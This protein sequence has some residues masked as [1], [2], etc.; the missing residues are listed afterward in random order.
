MP[1]W[2]GCRGRAVMFEKTGVAGWRA[3]E[4]TKGS[5]TGRHLPALDQGS[6]TIESTLTTMGVVWEVEVTC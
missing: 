2:A 3:E 1:E 5:W 4:E 6:A